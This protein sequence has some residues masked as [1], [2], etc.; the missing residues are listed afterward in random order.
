MVN[1]GKSIRVHGW[2]VTRQGPDDVLKSSGNF[3]VAQSLAGMEKISA[4]VCTDCGCVQTCAQT[5]ARC[6][7]EWV[8][9]QDVLACLKTST[10]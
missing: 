5:F 2:P 6:V 3:T 8:A 9:L 7:F 1:V 10:L 4:Q